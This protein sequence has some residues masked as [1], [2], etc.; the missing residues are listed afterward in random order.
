MIKDFDRFLQNFNDSLV[1]LIILEPQFILGPF[2][3]PMINCAPSVFDKLPDMHGR[4]Q[5]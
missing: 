4:G 2:T 1:T 5:R 3:S